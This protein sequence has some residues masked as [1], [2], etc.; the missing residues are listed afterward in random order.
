MIARQALVCWALGACVAVAPNRSLA[1]P[2][3]GAASSGSASRVQLQRRHAEL[4]G[5]LTRLDELNQQRSRAYV[6]SLRAGLLPLSG[7][8]D[9]LLAH[10]KRLGRSRRTLSRLLRQRATVAAELVHVANAL[11]EAARAAPAAAQAARARRALRAAEERQSAFRQAF[12]STW[13]PA[14]VYG[15]A[16]PA[17]TGASF[18]SQKGR[19]GF[20]IAGRTEVERVESP[21]GR[22]FALQFKAAV[23]SQARAIHAGRVAFADEYP[24]LGSTVIV[25]HGQQYFSVTAGLDA[26][27][28]EVGEELSIGSVLGSVSTRAGRGEALVEIRHAKEVEE[29]FA[30]FGLRKARR[31]RARR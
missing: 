8:F 28:V 16:Q 11:Q 19:L 31:P 15:A 5:A 3:A 17:A 25:E 20:P 18:A 27:T 1:L 6:R 9:E 10:A 7:G 30:W 29:P 24:G 21:T 14:V 13:Q 23:G 4:E 26:I 2:Q 22:G 12:N